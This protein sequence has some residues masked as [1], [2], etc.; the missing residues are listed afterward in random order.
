VRLQNS[1]GRGIAHVSKNAQLSTPHRSDGRKAFLAGLKA[2]KIFANNKCGYLPSA[3]EWR[4][5]DLPILRG[6]ADFGPHR[7]SGQPFEGRTR[8][9]RCTG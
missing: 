2:C 5:F 1:V 8:I 7:I 4:H 9:L 6:R 3:G